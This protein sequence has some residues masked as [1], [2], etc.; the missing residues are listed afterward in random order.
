MEQEHQSALAEA[1][2]TMLRSGIVGTA[3]SADTGWYESRCYTSGEI[4]TGQQGSLAGGEESAGGQLT[5]ETAA[6]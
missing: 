1:A 3:G 6:D 5:E 4:D 2:K